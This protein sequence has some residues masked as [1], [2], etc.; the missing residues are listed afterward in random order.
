[1]RWNFKAHHVMVLEAG[2]L[3]KELGHGTRTLMKR[4]ATL[5]KRHKRRLS[6]LRS[7]VCHVG[8]QLTD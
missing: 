1:M 7:S 8:T 4:L 2:V 5:I 6:L 3:G